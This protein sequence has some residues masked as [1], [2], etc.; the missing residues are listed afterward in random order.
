[1]WVKCG[2]IVKAGEEAFKAKDVNSLHE[3][4]SKATGAAIHEIDRLISQLAPQRGR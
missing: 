3:L 2:F 1:M 4:K